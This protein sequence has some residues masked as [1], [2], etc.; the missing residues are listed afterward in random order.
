MICFFFS[1]RRRHTRSTRDW[2][3]DVCSSDLLAADLVGSLVERNAVGLEMLPHPGQGFVGFFVVAESATLLAKGLRLT[4][5][6]A[7]VAQMAQG[8]GEMAFLDIGVQVF[9]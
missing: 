1:S 8:A 7:D 9:H 2:S 5:A 3:S 4:Q 6:V